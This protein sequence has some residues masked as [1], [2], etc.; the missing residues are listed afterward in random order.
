MA[1]AV[2]LHAI[3]QVL[4]APELA[5][6]DLAAVFA[7]DRRKSLGQCLHLV[8]GDILARDEDVLVE[9]HRSSAPS[10]CWWPGAGEDVPIAGSGSE[11]RRV[12][13]ECVRT[14]RS[15]WSPSH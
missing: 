15:R 13:K 5:L 9:R 8:G 4:Q 3:G 11:E 6:G 2:L 10:G 12:G 14:C 1:L 7:D